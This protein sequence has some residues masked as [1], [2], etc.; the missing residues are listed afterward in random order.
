MKQH[1]LDKKTKQKNLLQVE[2][3]VVQEI[4]PEDPDLW[5]SISL[6]FWASPIIIGSAGGFLPLLPLHCPQICSGRLGETA[7]QI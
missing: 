2:I 7:D 1:V 5:G 3:N 4:K 6:I